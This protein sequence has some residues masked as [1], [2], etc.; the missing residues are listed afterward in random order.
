M[1]Q[2]TAKNKK[3]KKGCKIAAGSTVIEVPYEDLRK[4]G[5]IYNHI[6]ISNPYV[7]PENR[8]FIKTQHFIIMNPGIDR[9]ESVKLNDNYI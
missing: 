9:D 5:R 4:G 1:S 6:N 7:S 2:D 3:K 8:I